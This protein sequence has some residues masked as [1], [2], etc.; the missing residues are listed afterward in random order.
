MRVMTRIALTLGVVA[1]AAP[2]AEAQQDFRW[3]GRVASD[4]AVSIRGISGDV[5]AHPAS[6]NQVEVVARKRGPNMERV[7]IEAYESDDGVLICAVYPG[8]RADEGRCRGGGEGRRGERENFGS[9]DFE[10]R[11]PAG[12][13]LKVAIVSGD[14][15]A[16]GL[17]G[18]V[19]LATVSGDIRVA[20]TGTV[21]AS[22]VSGDI[23]ATM[24]A[25]QRGGTSFNAVSGNVT[26]RMAANVGAEVRVN[27]LSGRIDSDFELDRPRRSES[28]WNIEVGRRARGRIGGGGP[29]LSVNTVSGDVALRRAR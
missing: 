3:S 17:R 26:L 29:E 9:V 24:G 27:T 13:R 12:V 6:G 7:R 10:V 19:E 15:N 20:T 4:G 1:A 8:S 2:A 16:V 25:M 14:V 5:S 18:P 11:V 21:T 23:D 28:R 22:S